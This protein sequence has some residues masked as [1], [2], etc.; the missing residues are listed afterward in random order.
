MTMAFL[1][2]DPMSRNIDLLHRD[3]LQDAIL[4]NTAAD[5][6]LTRTSTI[7]PKAL[8]QIAVEAEARLDLLPTPI[9]PALAPRA[10]AALGKVPAVGVAREDLARALVAFYELVLTKD[11]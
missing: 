6:T 1:G 4:S 2:P 8:P 5:T 10:D 7:R 9:T 3:H 11:S